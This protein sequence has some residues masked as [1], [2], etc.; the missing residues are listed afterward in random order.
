MIEIAYLAD[1]PEVVPTLVAWFQAQWP[2][3]YAGR[4]PAEITQDFYTEANR[5]GILIRLIAFVD[6]AFAGTITLRKHALQDFPEYQPGLGGL[7]ILADRLGQQAWFVCCQYNPGSYHFHLWRVSTFHQLT[8][9]VY[10]VFKELYRGVRY[11]AGWMARATASA[12]GCRQ[13]AA[14]IAS[15]PNSVSMVST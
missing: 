4:T 15:L 9:C 2:A 3:Y 12:P 10:F 14:H 8:H 1:H 5:T 13:A 7:M 6:G 11:P